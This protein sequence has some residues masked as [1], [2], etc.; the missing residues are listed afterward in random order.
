MRKLW[1]LVM[2]GG[3]ICAIWA[4]AA[5]L[6]RMAPDHLPAGGPQVQSVAVAGF[7]L[8]FDLSLDRP[9]MP[10]WG[11]QA[12]SAQLSLPSYWP[13]SAAG[14]LSGAQ[15]LTWRGATW[16]SDGPDMPVAL[17]ITPGLVLRAARLDARDM[18]WR[19]PLAGRIGTLALSLSSAESATARALDLDLDGLAL[20][21][22]DPTDA[23]LRAVLHMAAPPRM[24]A[25][26]VVARIEVTRARLKMGDI[27]AE[28]QGTLTR[29]PDGFWNG[30][31]TLAVTNWRAVLAR[32]QDAGMLAPD[33]A[34]MARVMAQRMSEGAR[35]SL[36]LT[37]S[38]SVFRLGPIAL[39]DLGRL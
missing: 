5:Q 9:A 26:P 2:L 38:E 6:L 17:E 31:L 8:R 34:A 23:A 39:L 19:G 14:A 22:L 29:A 28:A 18:A 20:A 15:T 30:S 11:W 36:P 13:F 10:A 25:R 4:G 24:T 35:L 12:R 21:G 27:R 16:R 33:A 3:A 1:V 7:P 37:V 32:L